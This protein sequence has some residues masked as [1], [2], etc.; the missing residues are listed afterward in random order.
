MKGTAKVKLKKSYFNST[1]FGVLLCSDYDCRKWTEKKASQKR[2][3]YH[4]E[5]IIIQL[6][7][8]DTYFVLILE[9]FI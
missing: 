5:I 8:Y 3:Y 4:T 6:S 2:L 1:L 7:M 9:C